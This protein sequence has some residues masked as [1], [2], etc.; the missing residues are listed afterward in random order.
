M[1]RRPQSRAC[2]IWWLGYL[3]LRL[4]SVRNRA[5]IVVMQ[6]TSYPRSLAILTSMFLAA[7]L[8]PA[9]LS[10]QDAPA[11]NAARGKA[12]FEAS[13]AVCHSPVLGPEN[14]VIMKQGPS[15]VGVVGRPAGSL[16]HFNYTKA[17]REL[18][19]TWDTA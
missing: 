10:A 13:C 17:I 1:H 9:N 2:P 16:P 8:A 18:G 12:F 6:N 7:A 14:L 5:R 3:P 19:L 15:L 11:G 4:Y